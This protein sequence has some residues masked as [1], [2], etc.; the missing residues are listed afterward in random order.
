MISASVS[1]LALVPHVQ[2][3]YET[4]EETNRRLLAGL[5]KVLGREHPYTLTSVSSGDEGGTKQPA[6]RGF[7]GRVSD[8]TP[9]P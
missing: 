8:H 7:G 2:G 9:L 6:N 5:E 3:K 4:A 1:N